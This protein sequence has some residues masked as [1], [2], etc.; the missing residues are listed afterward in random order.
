MTKLVQ[1]RTHF[2]MLHPSPSANNHHPWMESFI[3]TII[4]IVKHYQLT[5]YSPA[6]H[7]LRPP[8]LYTHSLQQ[9]QGPLPG[10][11]RAGGLR[12]RPCDHAIIW[13]CDHGR[14]M[15]LGGSWW[16]IRVIDHGD[17]MITDRKWWSIMLNYN[18]IDGYSDNNH[19]IMVMI[20]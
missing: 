16:P 15:V 5:I 12:S 13:S 17:K 10:I 6:Y 2:W 7:P 18:D 4:Q 20:S 8:P 11:T 14:L 3:L 19:D 1:H 9:N